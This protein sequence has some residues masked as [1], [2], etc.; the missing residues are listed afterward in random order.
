MAGHH[1]H[2]DHVGRDT[3]DR[4]VLWAV[5]VNIALTVAQVVG[6]ILS[7]S[8]A[9]IADALHNFSDAISL[10]IAFGARRIARRPANPA[11]TYGYARVE[12]VA[13]LIN[14]TTLILVG[15]YLLYEAAMRFAEPQPI[16]GWT[17]VIV[18]GIALVIDVVTALLTY[19]LSKE[20]INIR[21]AFLH[22]VAD[23]LGSV[24]VIIA[25]TL[26]LLYDW[27][28]VDP[29]VTVLIAAYV[30]WHA[31]AEIGGAIRILM[32]GTPEHIDAEKLV[33][34]LRGVEGVRDVHHVHVWAFDEHEAALEAHIVVRDEADGPEAAAIRRRIR[35]VA[36]DEFGIRHATLE[37]E[38]ASERPS[39]EQLVIGHRRR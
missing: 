15:L 25:G 20:S 28:I 34:A 39:E 7:G 16:A 3:G 29:V 27:R 35:G 9:L 23:A 12:V 6:G 17:V 32:L 38:P 14:Y 18:A 22:N 19:T 2:H 31:F 1:H 36:A 13:A 4:R 33:S 30:L 26:I 5:V 24:G 8:L 21:A 11:M 10:V 37:L